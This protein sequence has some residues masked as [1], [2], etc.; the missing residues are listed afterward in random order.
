MNSSLS[1]SKENNPQVIGQEIANNDQIEVKAA[2]QKGVSTNANRA[3][4]HG[5]L[6]R[7]LI[8]QQRF[9]PAHQELTEAIKIDPTN[10]VWHLHNSIALKALS[11][12]EEALAEASEAVILDHNNPEAINQFG[13]MLLETGKFDEAI[14]SFAEA[15]RLKPNDIWY[16]LH[17]A[18]AFQR[19]GKF[20][21]AIEIVEMLIEKDPKKANLYW[22]LVSLY[23]LIKSADQL[24]G[25]IDRAKT[26]GIANA[27]IYRHG[28]LQL[29]NLDESEKAK[30]LL[31]IGIEQFPEDPILMHMV[32]QASKKLPERT[33]ISFIQTKYQPIASEFESRLVTDYHRVPGLVRQ[34]ILQLRPKLDPSRAMPH[35]LSA[36]L[37]LGCGTGLLGLMINDL[38]TYIKGIDLSIPMLQIAQVKQVYREIEVIDIA[39]VIKSDLRLYEGIMAGSSIRYFGKLDDLISGIFKR[40]LPKGFCIF[41]LEA[42]DLD[43]SKSVTDYSLLPE[44]HFQHSRAYIEKCLIAAGFEIISIS[45]EALYMRNDKQVF[46]YLVMA[47]RP[48]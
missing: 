19:S 26:N 22:S 7:L 12:T 41:D 11:K 18:E 8:K 16:Y 38:T 37:D 48:L 47:I 17:L 3:R 25:T 20:N 44:G 32:E 35:R 43:K 46:G 9:A 40:T 24:V 21:S 34:A 14:I 15:V 23:G 30:K 28:A 4:V 45:E 10:P 36:V 33:P 1:S 27:E 39:E 31:T 2:I 42:G 5:S 6:G 29:F 13:L